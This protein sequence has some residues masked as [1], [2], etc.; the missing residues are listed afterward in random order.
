M[1]EDSYTLLA[2]RA[3]G[4]IPV[5]DLMVGVSRF[6]ALVRARAF[7]AEHRSC[8]RVEV[9]LEGR[10]VGEVARDPEAEAAPQPCAD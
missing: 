5:V 8:E 10:M 2:V 7:L 3:D 9:W 1:D 6:E 4:A